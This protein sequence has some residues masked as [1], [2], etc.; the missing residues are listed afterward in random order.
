MQPE[1]EGT[2]CRRQGVLGCRRT[3]YAVFAYLRPEFRGDV[4]LEGLLEDQLGPLE[5]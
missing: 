2:V 1:G 3:L 5:N 4:V